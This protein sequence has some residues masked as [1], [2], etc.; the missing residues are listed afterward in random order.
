MASDPSLRER[1]KVVQGMKERA[2]TPDDVDFGGGGD[3][4]GGM[5][6]L[7][8]RVGRLEDDVKELRADMKVVRAD[9]AWLKGRIEQLPTT[10]VLV[11]TIA[12]SQA[13]LLGFTFAILRYAG[14]H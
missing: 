2:P 11:T 8:F 6:D 3:N 14:A 10:W 5:S 7:P 12:A 9:L 1:F 4:S 13:A